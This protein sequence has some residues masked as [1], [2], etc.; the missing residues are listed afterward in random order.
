MKFTELKQATYADERLRKEKI[1]R[2]QL[3]LV[4]TVFCEKMF[5]ALVIG[6]KVSIP[7]LFTLNLRKNKG[8]R[9]VNPITKK[10][11]V[12]KD[13]YRVLVSQSGRLKDNLKEKASNEL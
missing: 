6:G 13:F 2:A 4:V 12:T 8:K 1:T 9:I 10:P 11:M 3:N 7:N 5:E